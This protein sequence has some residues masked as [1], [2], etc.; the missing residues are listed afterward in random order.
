MSTNGKLGIAAA[1][2]ASVTLYMAYVGTTADW[3]YFLTVEE[4]VHNASGLVN[5][6]I[7]VNGKVVQGTLEIETGRQQATFRIGEAD[8]ELSVLCDGPL[9]DN[10]GEEME[11]VVEGRLDASG[12]LRGDKVLTRCA[13]KYESGTGLSAQAVRPLE[14]GRR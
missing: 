13:S 5:Q 12:I 10:L 2:I 6:P 11:V 1:I 3:R 4:C 7:R 9:P 8:V 14:G